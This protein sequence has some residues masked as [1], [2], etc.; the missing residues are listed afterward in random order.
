MYPGSIAGAA[1]KANC[2][3]ANKILISAYAFV[4]AFATSSASVAGG[5]TG[6]GFAR[7]DFIFVITELTSG[8]TLAA[9]CS[10]ANFPPS[11]AASSTMFLSTSPCKT[12]IA[13]SFAAPVTF[14]G[15]PVRNAA[16]APCS[17]ALAC[18]II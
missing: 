13:A 14:A 12:A 4:P 8:S 6:G 1:D 11:A 3:V 10:C 7:Y 16:R 9:K 2:T 17:A 5:K 15:G 18:S